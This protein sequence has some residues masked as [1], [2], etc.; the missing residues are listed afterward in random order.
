V[1]VNRGKIAVWSGTGLVKPTP[2]IRKEVADCKFMTDKILAQG[3]G[4]TL[5]QALDTI[6]KKCPEFIAKSG[7]YVSTDHYRNF[8]D[9]VESRKLPVTDAETGCRSAILCLLCN[10]SYKHDAGFDWDPVKNEFANGTGHGISLR[11]DGD[12]N[13]WEVK[14]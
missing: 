6:E 8:T 4:K 9:C 7:I 14:A 11:R 5:G 1:A 2:E 10:M 12:C 3:G 13:G